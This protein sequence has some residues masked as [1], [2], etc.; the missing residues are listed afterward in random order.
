M[1]RLKRRIDVPLAS[2]HAP[3]TQTFIKKVCSLH[4]VWFKSPWGCCAKDGARPR[5]FRIGAAGVL[6]SIGLMVMVAQGM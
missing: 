6:Y 5:F 1:T 4:A 3:Q 2:Q